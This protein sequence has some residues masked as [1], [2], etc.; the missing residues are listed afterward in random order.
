MNMG[1]HK[2]ASQSVRQRRPPKAARA[3]RWSGV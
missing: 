3:G 2:A 1:F